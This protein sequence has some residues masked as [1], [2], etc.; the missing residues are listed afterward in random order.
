MKTIR[1]EVKLQFSFLETTARGGDKGEVTSYSI[2]LL[3][4]SPVACSAAISI[5]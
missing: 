4:I 5:G 1:A 3:I 2:K